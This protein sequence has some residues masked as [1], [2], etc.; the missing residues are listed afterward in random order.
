MAGTALAPLRLILMGIP[1]AVLT[2]RPILW[3][4]GGP[5]MGIT[6][7]AILLLP[8]FRIATSSGLA[9][10]DP[11]LDGMARLFRMPRLRRLRHITWPAL[12]TA[13]LP[14]LR[15][16]LANGLR[17]TLP[18]ELPGGR[19]RPG[20]AIRS[21]QTWLMTDR[22]FALTIVTLLLIAAP[23]ALLGRPDREA[24]RP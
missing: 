11:G 12:A 19:Q 17:I 7:V 3:L 5:V 8:V 1:A 14:A 6:A 23:E 13:L 24:V 16:A 15:L 9:A 21:A 18:V 2:I 10:G 20:R 4:D 22:L